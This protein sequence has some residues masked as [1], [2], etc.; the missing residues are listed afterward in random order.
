MATINKINDIKL[1]DNYFKSYKLG[2]KTLDEMLG[3]IKEKTIITIAA[4]PEMGKTN[5]INNIILNLLSEYNLPTLYVNLEEDKENS[6]IR[7]SSIYTKKPLKTI[8]EDKKLINE[9]VDNF[10]SKNYNLFISDDSLTILELENLLEENKNK[11]I[12]FLFINY[13]QNIKI[14]KDL[15]SKGDTCKGIA[16][17]IKKLSNKYNLVIF[18]SSQ[19]PRSIENRKNK[20]PLLSDL[21]NKGLEEISNIIIMLYHDYCYDTKVKSEIIVSKNSSGFIGKTYL[22]YDRDLLTFSDNN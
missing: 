6:L 8:K 16:D 20:R 19:L 4:R 12:K 2:Y 18:L 17:R 7:L 1:D 3:K 11:N 22:E 15:E 14:E 13:I 9:A 10:Q 21:K 5:F